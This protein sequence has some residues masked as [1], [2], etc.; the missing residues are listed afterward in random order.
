VKEMSAF[1]NFT[2][3]SIEYAQRGFPRNDPWETLYGHMFIDDVRL[4]I[5]PIGGRSRVRPNFSIDI[6]PDTPTIRQIMLW[7]FASRRRYARS[8]LQKVISDFIV[9]SASSMVHKGIVRYEITKAEWPEEESVSENIEREA[10]GNVQL[11]RP[12]RIHGIIAGLGFCYLQI[13]RAPRQSEVEIKRVT[14][15]RSDVWTL[16]IPKELGGI[17]KHKRLLKVLVYASKAAPEFFRQDVEKYHRQQSLAVASETADWGWEVRGLLKE[18]TTEYFQA[19]RHLRF[20]LSMAILRDYIVDSMNNLLQ[21][22][23]MSACISIRGLP[24][25]EDIKSYLTDLDEGE[26]TFEDARE[27]VR[28]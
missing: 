12:Q 3:K 24:T 21:K 15:P 8:D 28:I 7:A 19:Y 27:S 9:Q 2:R 5:M 16:R 17:W 13:V 10:M 26:L 14:I 11:F 23:G 1:P 22:V 4:H 6:K 25:Q 20:A 18:E